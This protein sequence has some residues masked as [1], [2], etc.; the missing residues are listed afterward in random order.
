[1]RIM[2]KIFTP[3]ERLFAL[4]I[5]ENRDID[6]PKNVETNLINGVRYGLSVRQETLDFVRSFYSRGEI[7]VD[8]KELA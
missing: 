7:E 1:M 8:L 4:S 5:L 6:I 3:A 2:S